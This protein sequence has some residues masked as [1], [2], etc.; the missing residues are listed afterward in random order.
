MRGT[1]T[2]DS[3]SNTTGAVAKLGA[4]TRATIEPHFRLE[5]H[6]QA[7]VLH[8]T[9]ALT[10]TGAVRA[11]R[12]CDQLRAAVRDLRVDLRAATYVDTSPLQAVAMLLMRWRRAQPG[13]QSRIDLPPVGLRPAP[14]PLPPAPRSKTARAARRTRV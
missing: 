1:D 14:V 11:V 2:S 7:A 9:G 13:R 12:L 4:P 8:V 6:H 5:S 3:T 10:V